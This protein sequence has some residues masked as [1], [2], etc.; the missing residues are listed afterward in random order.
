MPLSKQYLNSGVDAAENVNS[1]RV[2]EERRKI[3]EELHELAKLKT[4]TNSPQRK[5]IINLSLSAS[6]E[7]I[8]NEDTSDDEEFNEDEFNED[9]SDDEFNEDDYVPIE[10][11]NREI[12][13]EPASQ[14]TNNDI[15]KNESSGV[16]LLEEIEGEINDF[17]NK[18]V[19]MEKKS[20]WLKYFSSL[21][22][23][24]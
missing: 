2:E 22:C 13:S 7:E 3:E 20:G 6:R 21:V 8:N 4:V 17:M 24:S 10:V 14:T 15:S 12:E 19:V 11:F 1:K 5:D 9:E 16:S 18:S 23:S